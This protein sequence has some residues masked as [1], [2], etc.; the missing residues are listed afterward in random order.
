MENHGVNVLFA[1]VHKHKS[2]FCNKILHGFD[3]SNT[4]AS[5]FD[6]D[7]KLLPIAQ[8]IDYFGQ[9]LM[10]TRT[11][12]AIV[13]VVSKDIEDFVQLELE[14]FEKM[15]Q[16]PMALMVGLAIFIPTVAYV[17]LQATSSMFK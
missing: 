9:M 5:W 4:D 3:K 10:Y 16:I 7:G 12:K 11:V 14:R 8:T 13:T 2:L 15:K 6:E 17:T 1:W